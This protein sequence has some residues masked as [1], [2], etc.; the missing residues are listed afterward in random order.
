MEKSRKPKKRLVERR[1]DY[2]DPNAV[3][4][5]RLLAI[6][7]LGIVFLAGMIVGVKVD[8]Y[9][10]AAT[11]QTVRKANWAVEYSKS[12]GEYPYEW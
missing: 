6:I 9:A 10:E 1:L 4:N 11:L 3:A 5:R 12:I 2:R 8:A 7:I